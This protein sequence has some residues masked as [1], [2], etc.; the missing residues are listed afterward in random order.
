[1]PPFSREKKIVRS[2]CTQ[3][4]EV[5]FPRENRG[6]SAGGGGCLSEVGVSVKTI[7]LGHATR[8]TDAFLGICLGHGLSGPR[9]IRFFL[10]LRLFG[11]VSFYVPRFRNTETLFERPLDAAL[12]HLP[13]QCTMSD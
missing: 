1:M 9:V 6:G 10:R 11:S 4:E 7:T 5:V 2:H 12:S 3:E 8:V 13:F